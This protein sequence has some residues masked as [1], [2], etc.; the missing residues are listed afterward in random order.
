MYVNSFFFWIVLF[1]F[2]FFVVFLYCVGCCLFCRDEC[3]L[4]RYL[5]EFKGGVCCD[6]ERVVVCVWCN[7]LLLLGEYNKYKDRYIL[8]I[9]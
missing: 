1:F 2:V 5:M 4:L 3:F 9:I 8:N 6:D 7:D